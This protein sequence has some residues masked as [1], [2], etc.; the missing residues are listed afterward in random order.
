[1]VDVI[2]SRPTV[3]GD[4]TVLRALPRRGRRTVGPWCFA[5]HFGPANP[6]PT[7]SGSIGPHPHIG[8]QTATWLVAGAIVHRDSLGSEQLI[9]PGEL[10]LMTAGRGIAHA[11]E[12]DSDYFGP[13]HG[14][15]LW[16]A[17]PEATRNGEPGFAHH[18]DLPRTSIDDA[19][20]TVIVGEFEGLSSPARGDADHIAVELALDDGA[21]GLDLRPE[22]EYGVIVLT[23]EIALDGVA[24][25]PGNLGYLAPGRTGMVL[26]ANGDTRLM[27][28]GGLPFTEPLLMWWNFVARTREEIDDARASWQRADGRFGSVVSTLS[29]IDAPPTVW[30]RPG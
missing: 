30:A 19:I 15:Q 5:D 25:G 11:E 23:G 13:I 26:T 8:L 2:V 18:G 9:R 10:N 14:L 29:R 7:N 4:M 6:D 24:I 27:L 16:I 28:L 17:Q 20:A 12:R 1:M 3:V 21:I 22:F